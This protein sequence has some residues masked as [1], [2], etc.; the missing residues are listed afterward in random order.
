MDT[1]AE[2]VHLSR[3]VVIQGV[4]DSLTTED[5][6]GG[7][8]MAMKGSTVKIDGA[9]FRRMGQAGQIGRYPLH[10]HLAGD[11]TGSYVKNSSFHNNFNRC[12]TIHGTQNL[13]VENNVAY[14]SFGHCYFLED[15]SEF[16]NVLRNNI[17]LSIDKPKAEHVILPSDT[18][19]L[20]PSVFW[21]T[22]P[23]NVLENNIAAGADG[24]GFGTLSQSILQV[25]LRIRLFLY[26][27]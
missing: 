7:H 1:R 4:N 2:V 22:H 26:F 9:E 17:G 18:G 3:P 19:F 6:Y 20:G 16:G 27:T 5:L 8:V 25:Y 10:W 11:A 23:N 15:G 14:R 12:L 21:I 24:S 13:L